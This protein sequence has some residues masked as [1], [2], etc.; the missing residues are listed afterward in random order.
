[1]KKNDRDSGVVWAADL[2]VDQFKSDQDVAAQ[3]RRSFGQGIDRKEMGLVKV[4]ESAP[5]FS[6]HTLD[7]KPFSLPYSSRYRR[8]RFLVESAPGGGA[9]GLGR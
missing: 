4:G 9:L 6:A 1:M 3:I 5:D 7:G 2:A 8:A